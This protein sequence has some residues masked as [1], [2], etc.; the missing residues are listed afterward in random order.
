MSVGSKLQ[1][2]K[3]INCL[4]SRFVDGVR[5]LD[6]FA[7]DELPD[8]TRE[9]RPLCLILNTIPKTQPGIHWLAFNAPLTG[10]IKLFHLF[11]GFLLYID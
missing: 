2:G 9:L 5:W 8:V 11:C 6:V 4:I 3:M 10:G 1:A 7:R